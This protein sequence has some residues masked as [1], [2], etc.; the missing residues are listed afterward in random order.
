MRRKLTGEPDRAAPVRVAAEHVTVGLGGGVADHVAVAV[1][2]QDVGAL[3]VVAAE[4]ADAVVAEEL[5]L[6]QEG[7]EHAQQ[8][9]ATGDGEQ[10]VAVAVV[11]V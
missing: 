6:I 11:L 2:M 8:A 3:E 4:G 1:E 5:V 9:R 10:V 7:G